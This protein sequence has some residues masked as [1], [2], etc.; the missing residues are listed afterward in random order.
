[1]ATDF[2]TDLDTY[3]RVI[4]SDDINATRINDPWDAVIAI[5]TKVGE[6]ES[7]SSDSFDYKIWGPSSNG[8]FAS[9]RKLWIYEDD[10]SIPTGWSLVSAVGDR[11]LGIKGGSTYTTGGATAG[12]WSHSH[13]QSGTHTH[14]I[15]SDSHTHGWSG[16]GYLQPAGGDNCTF[17]AE[18]HNHTGT[19][20]AN[21]SSTN[22]NTT[23]RPESC[24]GLI[25]EKD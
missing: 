16:A 3:V 9:G 7:A 20:E 6:D 23:F 17:D 14:G 12:T 13:T 19:T 21:S 2:P 25:I 18:S 24:V 10:G 4:T 22:A 11:V 1:M 8:F 5:Q 15:Q